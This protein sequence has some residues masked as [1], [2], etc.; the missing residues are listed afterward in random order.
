MTLHVAII[1][2]D[3]SGKST[4]TPALASLAAAEL[5][6][7]AA[8]VGEDVWCKTPIEDL[9][10]PGFAPDGQMLSVRLGRLFQWM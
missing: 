8:A 1:G 7:T 3:G 10:M 5:G 6:V 4:V 9:C 2:I